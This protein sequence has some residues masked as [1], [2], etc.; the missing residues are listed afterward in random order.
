ME[1]FASN[2]PVILVVLAVALVVLG[3]LRRLVKLA[4]MGVALAVIGFAIWSAIGS[5]T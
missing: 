4:F 5:P 2:W 3:L 1:W